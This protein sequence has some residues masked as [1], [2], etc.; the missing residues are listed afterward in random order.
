MGAAV[1]FWGSMVTAKF[2]SE[3]SPMSSTKTC[4]IEISRDPKSP[5]QC[6]LFI[7]NFLIIQNMQSM[8][9]HCTGI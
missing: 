2:M 8:F 7:L 4:E 6:G 1:T 9:K 3:Q 5:W